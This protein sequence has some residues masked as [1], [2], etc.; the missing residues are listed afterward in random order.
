[1]KTAHGESVVVIGAGIV[2]LCVAYSVSKAGFA[3]TVVDPNPVASQCS[4]GNSGAISSSA[5]APLAMPG[6]LKT[7]PSML[8]DPTGPL[9]VP[10]SYI[11]SVAPWLARFI[12]AARPERVRQIAEGLNA[13]HDGAVKFHQE[14]AA[15][16]GC[17]ERIRTTGQLHLYPDDE[18]LDK[19]R[20][21]WALKEA[22]GLVSE[23]LDRAGIVELEPAIGPSY[24]TG[25]F[26]PDQAW[27]SEP[28]E[29]ARCIATAARERGV[30]FVEASVDAIR[31]A[32]DDWRIEAGNA[33]LSARYVV[34][35][36]G[37]WSAHLLGAFGIRV[38][39]ESQRGYHVQ[40]R[41]PGVNVSRQVVLANR[42]V[43]ITPMEHGLRVAGTVEF[44]GL[45]RP[46]SEAR[47]RLLLDHAIAGLPT[48]DKTGQPT[49][50]MGHRPCLPDSLPVIGPVPSLQGLWC[51]FGHGHLGVTGS[52]QTGRLIADALRG[53]LGLSKLKP[54]DIARFA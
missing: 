53:R 8:L 44:G 27:V 49:T 37:A 54:F 52:A 6:L 12:A 32:G 24:R 29:Y 28:R 2:G 10:A 22:Y 48:L 21:S 51:A 40:L 50:W 36:A 33:A 4:A 23:K 35:A 9:Y 46:P 42:K 31:R 11:L 18:A 16:V 43:F 1:M 17:Y 30:R 45:D 26:L 38:P 14:L 15:E 39:L 34:L 3:V 20:G 19:D 47:A 13:L 5:V 41:T 7:V 25:L